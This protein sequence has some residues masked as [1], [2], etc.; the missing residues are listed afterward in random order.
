MVRLFHA[1]FPTRTVLLTLSEAILLVLAFLLAVLIA[2]GTTANAG[3]FLLYESGL[4]RI[5]FT[6][7]VV[8]VMIYYFD[9]YSSMVLSNTREVFTRLVGVLGCTFLALAV[10]YFVVPDVKLNATI[11]WVGLLAASVAL[12]AW[13]SFFFMLNHSPRFA[14]QALILGDGPLA[15]LLSYEISHRPELG[16]RV[17]GAVVHDISIAGVR[18]VD[19]GDLT[20]FAKRTR[21]RR[22]IVTASE[23]R[24]TL[25]ARRLAG[26]QVQRCRNSR[27]CGI[28]REHHR[29]AGVGFPQARLVAV[30]ARLPSRRTIARLQAGCV[31]R[32]RGICAGSS[33]TGS[34]H[35]GVG[36][37]PGFERPRHFSPGSR[38]RRWQG[39]YDV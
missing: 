37:P 13:R 32:S 33:F 20:G 16:V 5:A 24:G 14:E 35:R 18:T 39:F 17:A 30:L 28:L 1:Y 12:P 31:D 21:V 2:T 10:V 4:A 38:R 9:L 27:R 8:L 36:D 23:R 29:E 34:R 3:I 6:V 25:P 7:A 22:V 19:S 26:T 15:G 11:L